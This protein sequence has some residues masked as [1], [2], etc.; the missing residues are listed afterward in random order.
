MAQF[1]NNLLEL[2]RSKGIADEEL[3]I[4]LNAH[5]RSAGHRSETNEVFYPKSDTPVLALIYKGGRLQEVRAEMNLPQSAIEELCDT[6]YRDYVGDVG[7]GFRLDVLFCHLPVNGAWRYRD[8][9]QILPIPSTAPRP[10]FFYAEHPF[11]L[12]YSF[13]ATKNGHTSG[14]RS[15]R[16]LRRLELLLGVLLTVRFRSEHFRSAEAT[17]RWVM[18][19]NTT[20]DGP[21]CAYQQLGYYWKD[22]RPELGGL[23]SPDETPF[24]QCVPASKY[25]VDLLPLSRELTLPDDLSDSLDCFFELDADNQR[26][27]LQACFWFTQAFQSM[28]MSASFINLIQAVETLM[29]RAKAEGRC[30]VCKKELKLGPTKLF[31]SFMDEYAPMSPTNNEMRE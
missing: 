4:F 29:P 23:S 27:F 1:K 5:F 10:P 25:Y 8:V 22:L 19:L 28:S 6:I 17:H 14:E 26:R 9:F 20:S 24:I 31:Q 12:E 2:F 13:P 18:D 7:T 30:P 3:P 15:V 21:K 11:L 16:E